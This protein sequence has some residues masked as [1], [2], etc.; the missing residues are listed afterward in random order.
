MCDV[1][2]SFSFVTTKV[3]VKVLAHPIYKHQVYLLTFT[4]N[5]K[6]L[7]YHIIYPFFLPLS[8]ATI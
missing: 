7:E 8:F 2:F 6:H 5:L 3:K 1:L 4:E